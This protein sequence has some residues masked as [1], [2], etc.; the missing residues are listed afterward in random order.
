[1]LQKDELSQTGGPIDLEKNGH[2][3]NWAA[4][5]EAFGRKAGERLDFSA[6]INPLGPPPALR[7]M[8]LDEWDY[9]TR[10]PDPEV[11]E[12]RQAISSKYGVPF[13]SILVGNGAAELIDLLPRA[14]RFRRAAVTDPTFSEYREALEKAG[15]DV[16]SVTSSP[17][18]RFR[19]EPSKLID[20][21]PQ[22]DALFLGQPNNP[23]GER[24][25]RD[26]LRELARQAHKH[27]AKLVLDEAF[28]DFFPDES[29]VTMIREAA[30]SEHIVVIRSMTK[31]YAIPGLRLGFIVA[32]PAMI[33][34]LRRLQMPWSVNHFAQKAGVLALQDHEYE[35]RTR[36][37]I[38]VERSWLQNRLYGLGCTAFDSVAN[39]L[40]VA[41]GPSHIPANEMQ[42]RLA[43]QG[44]FIRR[45]ATFIGLDDRYFRI[46]VRTRP[47]NERLVAALAASLLGGGETAT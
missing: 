30:A 1:M 46:A 39:F 45:C 18:E 47:E 23:T 2:G 9:I 29:N 11:R 37:L 16:V 22:V 40:L 3:G 26:E 8:L 10:Y 5:E 27:G 24:R 12:L 13:D 33:R 35:R 36:E 19:I 14:L 6:N 34:E 28:A 44:I 20:V 43:E 25:E 32:G 41:L 31:F 17:E 21:L 15:A 4:A 42:R 38:A 7:H